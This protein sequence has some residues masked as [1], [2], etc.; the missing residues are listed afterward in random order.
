MYYIQSKYWYRWTVHVHDCEC[1]WSR[2]N[3]STR[4]RHNLGPLWAHSVALKSAKL[5]G[6]L[7]KY[8]HG[9]NGI[10]NKYYTCT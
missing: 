3:A 10:K 9:S 8:F 5:N 4:S 7:L 1:T 2:A 6:D